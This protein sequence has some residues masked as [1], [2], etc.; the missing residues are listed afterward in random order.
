[1]VGDSILG[2]SDL[3][4]QWSHL[5]GPVNSTGFCLYKAATKVG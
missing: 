3:H 2:E 5:N 1:M 4:G